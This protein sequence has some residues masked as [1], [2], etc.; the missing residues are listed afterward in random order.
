[1]T[2]Q[3]EQRPISTNLPSLYWIMGNVL[4]EISA[5]SDVKDPFSDFLDMLDLDIPVD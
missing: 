3:S 2:G 5:R 4:P 1:M